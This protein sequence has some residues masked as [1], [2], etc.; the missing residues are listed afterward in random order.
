MTAIAFLINL[1]SIRKLEEAG[2]SEELKQ[3]KNSLLWNIGLL[4]EG[5]SEILI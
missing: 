1:N 2:R 5:N 4:K 3:E